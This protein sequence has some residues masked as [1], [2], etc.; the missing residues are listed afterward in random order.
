M[1]FINLLKAFKEGQLIRRHCWDWDKC[2]GIDED[3]MFQ[4]FGGL[5]KRFIK[6]N[7]IIQIEDLE[8][9]DWEFYFPRKEVITKK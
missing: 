7:F 9:T 6:L 1:R 3:G 5:N 4:R 2:C 8:A